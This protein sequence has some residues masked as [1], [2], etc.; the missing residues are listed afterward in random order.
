MVMSQIA[1]H[2]PVTHAGDTPG[3]LVGRLVGV[4]PFYHVPWGSG[5][6]MKS[7]RSRFTVEARVTA[8]FATE[9]VV[10]RIVGDDADAPWQRDQYFFPRELHREYGKCPCP[11]CVPG[12]AGIREY[13]GA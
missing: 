1:S 8:T 5:G 3:S 12:G 9:L 2:A 6:S 10:V 13:G 7:V 4:R 11:A